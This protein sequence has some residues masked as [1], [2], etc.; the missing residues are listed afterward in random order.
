MGQIERISPE[1]DV[2]IGDTT[3]SE[4]HREDNAQTIARLK[5]YLYAGWLW[6]GLSLL[7]VYAASRRWERGSET[8]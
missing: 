4:L 5:L 7:A 6:T 3:L 1:H 8:R 2:Q